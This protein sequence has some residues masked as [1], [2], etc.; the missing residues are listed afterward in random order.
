VTRSRTLNLGTAFSAWGA[1]I[2]EVFLTAFA[3]IFIEAELQE[4]ETPYPLN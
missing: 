2:A 1:A 3:N 4:G